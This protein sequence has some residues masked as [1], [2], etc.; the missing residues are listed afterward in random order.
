MKDLEG[1]LETQALSRP[2][3]Q[4]TDVAAQLVIRQN[5]QVGV[6]GQVLTQQAVGIF[7]GLKLKLGTVTNGGTLVGLRKKVSRN[8]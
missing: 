7:I 8:R 4:R 5:A 6:L 3:V 2:M 1:A